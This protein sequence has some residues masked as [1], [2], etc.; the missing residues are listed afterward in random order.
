MIHPTAFVGGLA[1]A[2]VRRGATLAPWTPALEVQ[3]VAGADGHTV[4]TPR[5]TV[6]G[7]HV[8]LAC[9][10]RVV[11]FVP[12]LARVVTPARGQV[13]AT[14]TLPSLF[15]CGLALDWGSLYWRQAPDGAI[16]LG[17]YRGLDPDG[18]VG[19]DEV[20]HPHIQEKLGCF[21]AEAFPAF[22]EYRVVRRWAG[23]MDV[24]PDGR[25][26]IGPLPGTPTLWLV[27]GFGGHGLPAGLGAGRAVAESIHASQPQPVLTPFA[28]ER[29]LAPGDSL[30]GQAAC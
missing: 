15:T 22:P 12:G 9:A 11:R 4:A 18:E 20:L 8:V 3:P 25:P 13:L 19:E 7:R 23:I 26:I 1:A 28:P 14:D 2:A 30:R 17:G 10:S 16:V 24:T 29:F 6:R 21:L 27:C 5:G